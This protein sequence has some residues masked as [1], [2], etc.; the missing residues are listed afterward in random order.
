MKLLLIIFLFPVC[1]NAQPQ[2]NRIINKDTMMVPKLIFNTN[3]LLKISPA[4][5]SSKNDFNFFIGKWRLHN[6]VLKLTA[7]GTKEW[8]E[9]EATQEMHVILKGIGNIDNFLATRDGK[10]FEGMTL[11]LFNP[12]TR[13]WTIYWADSNYGILYLPAVVGSF[14]NKI[15][16][17]FSQ[18]DMN[19]KKLITVY[20]WDARDADNPI[21]SQAT[22]EDNGQS[23]E[24]N[25]YMN[26]SRIK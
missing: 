15:G 19:G 5:T 6:R 12:E 9:F 4:K 21:W 17:F 2:N 11:R 10:P 23:W 16:H 25:W 3:G 22:S 7:S 18:D 24:W 13:L 8:K 14:E 1:I 20:R 26:M